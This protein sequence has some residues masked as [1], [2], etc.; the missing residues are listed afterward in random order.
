MVLAVPS[1]LGSAGVEH[2][3]GPGD[4]FSFGNPAFC[5]PKDLVRD[6][7]LSRLPPVRE[8]PESGDLPFAP[9]TVSLVGYGGHVLPIGE[10]FGYELWSENYVGRT[11]LH[12][13]LTAQMFAVSRSGTTGQEVDRE[14]IEVPTISSG[15]QIALYLDPARQPGFY[16]YDLSI[17]NEEGKVLGRYSEY[18]KVFAKEFWKVRLG[19]SR[20][21]VRPGQRILSRVE[22]LGTVPV[23][24]GEDFS[25][26]RFDG[27]DWIGVPEATPGLVA[28]W[29]GN[30]AAGGTGRCSALSLP[31]DFPLGRYRIVKRVNPG[32]RFPGRRLYHLAA[33]F[34]VIK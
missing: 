2:R 21:R 4:P 32:S 8:V 15:D 24:Y 28:S 6:F 29:L 18:L 9:K 7:G 16:R 5:S 14:E 33:P 30:V 1:S 34:K 31:R 11:P 26:Q 17:S 23:R 13:T 12:W 3:T 25:V 27:S 19:L 22:N 20:R 10:S